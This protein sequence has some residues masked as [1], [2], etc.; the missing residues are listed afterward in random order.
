MR[1]KMPET[2]GD[3]SPMWTR[4]FWQGFLGPTARF[5]WLPSTVPS[6]IGRHLTPDDGI[7]VKEAMQ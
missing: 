3:S 1:F 6:Y 7:R 2:E 4:Q 5:P